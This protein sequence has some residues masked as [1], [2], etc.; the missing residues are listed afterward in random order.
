MTSLEGLEECDEEGR[1][2]LFALIWTKR[3]TLGQCAL[4]NLI[5]V[6]EKYKITFCRF[7]RRREKENGSDRR[8]SFLREP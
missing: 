7:G 4:G 8:A 1:L 5:L 3:H 6:E 2:R